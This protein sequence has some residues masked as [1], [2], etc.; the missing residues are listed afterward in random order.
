MADAPRNPRALPQELLVMIVEHLSDDLLSLSD[1]SLV[2]HG[3]VDMS[4]R[5]LFRTV[6]VQAHTNDE[7]FREFVSCLQTAPRISRSIRELYLEMGNVG[8][9]R[10]SI[11]IDTL[12]SIITQLSSLHSLYLRYTDVTIGQFTDNTLLMPGAGKFLDFLSLESISIHEDDEPSKVLA[13]FFGL[14]SSL[15]YLECGRLFA[16]QTAAAYKLFDNYAALLS[17]LQIRSIKF[18]KMPHVYILELLQN[19]GIHASLE[20]L[21][22]SY[23][24]GINM[25]SINSLISYV[26]QTLLEFTFDYRGALNYD[27]VKTSPDLSGCLNL[28]SITFGTP[29]AGSVYANEYQEIFTALLNTLDHAANTLREISFLF[30]VNTTS[31]Q[32]ELLQCLPSCDWTRLDMMLSESNRWPQLEEANFRFVQELEGEEL[33]NCLEIIRSGLP[34]AASR[35]VLRVECDYASSRSTSVSS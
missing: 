11:D 2:C 30:G 7:R 23:D 21:T 6:H 10:P 24:S 26:R 33:Q 28:R 32:D 22:V 35:R 31:T 5:I 29:Y 14:F 1:C 17:N 13:G 9:R 8:Q 3:W 4:S 25:D 12:G 18:V 15:N 20:I 27:V 34:G 16:K 19:T